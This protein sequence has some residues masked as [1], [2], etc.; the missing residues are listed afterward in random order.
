MA[1]RGVHL[2]QPGKLSLADGQLV[3]EQADGTARLPLEDI[4]WLVIDTPQATITTALLSACMAHGVALVSTDARHTPSGLMLPFHGHHRQAAVAVLQAGQSAPRRKRL[5]QKVVQAKITNQAN[6]LTACGHDGRAVAAM[7][8][9][10][11]SGDLT[12]VEA[13]AARAYWGGLFTKFR[14]EDGADKRNML[15]NYGYAVVRA[16]VARALV[17]SGLLPAFGI[18]HA[19]ASNAFNLADDM[20]EPFRP[21]VDHAV[22]AMSDGGIVRDGEPSLAERREL[23]SLPLRSVKMRHEVMSLLAATELA[24]ASLVRAMET[25]TPAVLILPEFAPVP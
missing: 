2:T 24:A 9:L 15:L 19:S 6:A 10:V 3:V 8:T 4:A 11:G 21:F 12:N 20:V 16:A 13:R 1:W 23:A 5:W 17:A 18:G 22:F 25:G 14:R 7:A